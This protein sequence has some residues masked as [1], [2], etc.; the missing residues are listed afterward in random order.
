MKRPLYL[1]GA[2]LATTANACADPPSPGGDSPALDPIVRDSAD[3][4]I[5]ENPRPPSASRLGWRVGPE[6]EVSIGAREGE[7]PYLL[8]RASDAFTL[9]DGRIVVANTGSHELRV[10]DASGIHV[11]T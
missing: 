6:P 1:A 5:I 7:G 8:H 2:I 3:V 4:R 11:A 9:S 10:F